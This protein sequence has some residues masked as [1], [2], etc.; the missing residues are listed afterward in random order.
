M[1]NQL[2]STRL[3][4]LLTFLILL[5]SCKTTRTAVVDQAPPAVEQTQRPAQ[6]SPP[7]TSSDNWQ[8]QLKTTFRSSYKKAAE[9]NLERIQSEYPV[10]TQDFLNMTLIRSNGERIRFKM[11]K[12]VYFTLAHTSHPPLTLYSYLYAA[13]FEINRDSTLQTLKDYSELLEQSITG[14]TEVNHLTE[15]QKERSLM[16]LRK[17][18]EYTDK[19]IEARST[20]KAEFRAFADSLREPI[21]A[22]T[23]DSAA[24]QINQFKARLETW[25]QE[26]PEENWKEL[27]VAVMGVHQP[28]N[29]YLPSQFF[30]WLLDEP[31][32]EKRVIYAEYQFSIF[33]QNRKKAIDLALMVL[34]KVDLDK[35]VALFLLGEET[36][37]QRDITGP[38]AKK[39]IEGWGK[40]TW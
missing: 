39:I 17:S 27:R 3:L 4:T 18:K 16:I 35:E 23:F 1:K 14:L 36:M 32:F 29:D 33:G 7:T 28:R 24:E 15:E 13:D 10:I 11:D 40:S 12:K 9:K 5:S 21:E 34:A 2:I 8:S 20:T 26:Y 22:N 31:E 6:T 25:K 38:A 19:I 30:R 37:L